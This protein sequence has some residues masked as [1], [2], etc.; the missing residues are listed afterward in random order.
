MPVDNAAFI[1]SIISYMKAKSLQHERINHEE[2]LAVEIVGGETMEGIHRKVS[3]WAAHWAL[4]KHTKSELRL[5]L[6]LQE[7]GHLLAWSD[8]EDRGADA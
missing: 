6:E 1:E 3:L 2:L 7:P 5:Q 8:W 4:D